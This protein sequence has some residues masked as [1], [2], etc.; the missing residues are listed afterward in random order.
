MI[1]FLEAENKARMPLTQQLQNIKL[2]VRSNITIII[3]IGL[4]IRVKKTGK[5]EMKFL[6]L[7]TAEERSAELQGIKSTYRNKTLELE[8]R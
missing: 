6:F 7:Q 8:G 1:Y 4:Q 5:K 2:D 3:I